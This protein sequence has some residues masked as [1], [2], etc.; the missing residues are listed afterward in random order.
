MRNRREVC[1]KHCNG[2]FRV[3]LKILL[4]ANFFR[5]V[6]GAGF[7]ELVAKYCEF[8]ADDL[9][10]MHTLTLNELRIASMFGRT[11]T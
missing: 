5:D 9:W 7:H 4:G 3:R 8:I 10:V 1:L 11:C 6:L 2:D